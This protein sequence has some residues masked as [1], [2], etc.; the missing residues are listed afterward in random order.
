MGL[1]EDVPVLS[2]EQTIRLTR[3]RPANHRSDPLVVDVF[4][5]SLNTNPQ[6][7]CLSYC[8]GSST[9]TIPLICNDK[10]VNIGENL[11]RALS[12]I[13][14]LT[15]L[16]LWVDQICVNQEDLPERTAQV[17]LMTRIYSQ[18]TETFAYLGEPDSDVSEEALGIMEVLFRP[19]MI[20]FKLVGENTIAT[21]LRASVTAAKL[22]LQHPY[23][24]KRSYDKDVISAINKLLGC[25]YFGRKWIIQEVALSRSVFCVLGLHRF[26]WNM[27]LMAVARASSKVSELFTESQLR[28]L[29]LVCLVEDLQHKRPRSLLPLLYYSRVFKSSDPRDH[30]FALLGAA[31]DSADFAKPDYETAEEQ[32]YHDTSSSFVRQGNGH[33]MLRLAGLRPTDNGLPSWVV[34]WRNLDTLYHYKYFAT[35]RAGG[36]DG[37]LEPTTNPAIIRASGKVVDHVLAIAEPFTAEKDLWKR[38]A[39]YIESTTDALGEFYDEKRGRQAIRRDLA[40]L[41]SFEMK[42]DSKD[43]DRTICMFDRDEWD[44]FRC[45]DTEPAATLKKSQFPPAIYRFFLNKFE[46]WL[47]K[48]DGKIGTA[49]LGRLCQKLKLPETSRS[50]GEDAMVNALVASNAFETGLR[51]NFFHP[52]TRPIMTQN[53]RLG[54]APVLT[55]KD[56]VV[57]VMLGANAPFILRPAGDGTYQIV[58]E[59][60][61]RDIMFGETLQDDRYPTEE[62]L[63]R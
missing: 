15:K 6:Y 49:C 55:Q 28:L 22:A 45:M 56:D 63:I 13:R 37:C 47:S 30:V 19:V 18:A 42:F 24:L 57:C 54:L 14:S 52:N 46:K 17:T 59:V 21:Q 36:R 40:S 4:P 5:V 2:T 53:R 51:C 48:K 60:Y 7:A 16:P 10:V 1:Y 20:L 32:V 50:L 43:P 58:G 61:V 31:S 41:I 27:F 38:L 39:Q 8:W 23:L 9:R 62:I 35:F 25:P 34:D 33:L 12:S 44:L 26:E 29:W 3:F 11:E